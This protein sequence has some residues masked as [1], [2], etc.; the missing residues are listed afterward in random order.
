MVTVNLRQ[1]P[2]ATALL[3]IGFRSPLV[4]RVLNFTVDVLALYQIAEMPGHSVR[5]HQPDI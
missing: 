5:V 4:Y 3:Q 1:R 2:I